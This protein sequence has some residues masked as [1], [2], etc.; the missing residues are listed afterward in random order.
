[1][2]IIHE[3]DAKTQE[4]VN[5][6]QKQIESIT[7][8]YEAKFQPQTATACVKLLRPGYEKAIIREYQEAISPYQKILAKLYS[9]SV[10]KIIIKI[11]KESD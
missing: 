10:S 1:M 11:N 9:T 3:Y 7:K 2:E 6:I 8:Q 4:L 5:Q